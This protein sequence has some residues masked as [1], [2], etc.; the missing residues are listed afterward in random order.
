MNH[1]SFIVFLLSITMLFFLQLGPPIVDLVNPE[2]LGTEEGY[3][4]QF[5]NGCDIDRVRWTVFGVDIFF[6]LLGFVL[7]SWIMITNFRKFARDG[8]QLA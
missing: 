6:A 1:R 3:L 4:D 8:A 5:C 7:V 2:H